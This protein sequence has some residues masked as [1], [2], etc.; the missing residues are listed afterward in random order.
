MYSIFSV[1][2]NVQTGSGAHQ[3]PGTISPGGGVK[4]PGREADHSAPSNADVKNVGAIPP[5]LHTSSWSLISQ[6]HG[7]VYIYLYLTIFTISVLIEVAL[8]ARDFP[9][10]PLDVRKS[11]SAKERNVIGLFL[12]SRFLAALSQWKD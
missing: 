1:L 4:C 8:R 3:V 5:L 6:A 2:H 10:N 7:E 11:Y 9:R 12:A